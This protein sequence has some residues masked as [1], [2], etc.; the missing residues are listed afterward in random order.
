MYYVALAMVPFLSLVVFAVVELAMVSLD[1]C[2]ETRLLRWLCPMALLCL[3]VYVFLASRNGSLPYFDL[4]RDDLYGDDRLFFELIMRPFLTHG[5]VL[6]VCVCALLGCAITLGFTWG[7]A[8][9][10]GLKR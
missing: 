10:R 1:I 5:Y 4:V 8:K 2:L 6:A 7:D 9:K 3:G